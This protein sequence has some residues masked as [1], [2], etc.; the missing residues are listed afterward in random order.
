MILTAYSKAV[1]VID[2]CENI[3][4]IIGAKRYINNF[5]KKYSVE[6]NRGFF[7]NQQVADYYE[8]LKRQLDIKTM[9]LRTG[10]SAG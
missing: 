5:F 7:V 3:D 10:S 8:E 1:K 4:H 9:K 2:S 6:K